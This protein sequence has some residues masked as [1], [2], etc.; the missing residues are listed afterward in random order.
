MREIGFVRGKHFFR[1]KGGLRQVVRFKRRR[2]APA[3]RV[4]IETM[5]RDPFATPST[6]LTVFCA[7]LGL[8]RLHY[9][10]WRHFWHMERHDEAL[11]EFRKN[12][13]FFDEYFST[14]PLI[15]GIE[16]ASKT[17]ETLSCLLDPDR[18]KLLEARK[19]LWRAM[20]KIAAGLRQSEDSKEEEKED[21]DIG[22]IDGITPANV[23]LLSLLTYECGDL[24]ASI[25]HTRT[26][27]F[28]T[29]RL[30][31]DRVPE[32]RKRQVAALCPE[33]LNPDSH[34]ANYLT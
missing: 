4:E 16:E 5:V 19:T 25:Q 33:L 24:E 15:T 21:E 32:S 20:E 7:E 3:L 26:W 17:C 1:D 6:Y 28:G 12:L 14:A 22:I 31:R 8:G 27:W 30:P 34:S 10:P 9:M 23:L 29:E 13:P 18:E 2:K 11:A